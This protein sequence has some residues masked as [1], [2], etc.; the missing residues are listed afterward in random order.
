MAVFTARGQRPVDHLARAAGQQLGQ[1]AA[2]ARHTRVR[3]VQHESRILGV[4]EAGGGRESLFTVA[5]GAL[6]ASAPPG[7]LLAMRAHVAV[8]AA[9]CLRLKREHAGRRSKL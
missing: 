1:V 9:Q 5:D 8:G 6:I 2:G 4:I 3:A 7:E